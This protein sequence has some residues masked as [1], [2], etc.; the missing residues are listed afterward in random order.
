MGRAY[1]TKMKNFA[2]FNRGFTLIEIMIVVA[3]IALLA[4]VAI[5]GFRAYVH[6][7]KTNLCVSNIDTLN[8]AAETYLI[9]HNLD[10]EAAITLDMLAP[11]EGSTDSCSFVLKRRPVCPVGG[12]YIYDPKDHVWT[13]TASHENE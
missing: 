6:T 10:S 12:E 7:S 11:P 3:I 2:S 13:C 4:A 1:I 5:P 8:R 9:S